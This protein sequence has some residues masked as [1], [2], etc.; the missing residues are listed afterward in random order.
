MSALRIVTVVGARPQF[1]KAAVLSRAFRAV[2]PNIAIERLVHTGQHYDDNMSDVFFGELGIQAPSRH[3]G[4]SG[5]GH[6]AMT[7]QMLERLEP[8]L[9]DERPDLVLVYGDTNSTLAGTLAAVKLGIPVAHVEAGLRSGNL[10][11]PEEINRVMT[12]RVSRWLFCPTDT[13][14]EHLLREGLPP[15]RIYQVGDVMYDAALHWASRG[16]ES[17]L[18]IGLLERYP[19]GFCLA[20]VHRAE[21]TEDVTR[22]RG[23]VAALEEIAALVP[24]VLPLHPRTR[25]SLA[26]AG[27][28]LR[29]VEIMD[30]VGYLDMTGL[31]RSCQSVLTDSGGLQ[32]EAFFFEKPCVTMR[33]E[34]EWTE[35][36]ELG[37]NFVVG[38]DTAA[39]VKA[40]KEMRRVRPRWGQKPYGDG[41]AG[42]RILDILLR[43]YRS[44]AFSAS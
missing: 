30:P 38:T 9:L 3:L 12:D 27:I 36:V 10:A 4:V 1:I 20:T 42:E 13:A 19:N 32:K 41:T 17:K 21:N 14:V 26:A 31:L 7:G 16:H 33:E 35:L 40:W 39:I 23:I 24:V 11:M 44:V 37:A 25:G 29:R 18:L 22:L 6:G 5:G 28:S 15:Q 34:T 2:G 8:V 43:D